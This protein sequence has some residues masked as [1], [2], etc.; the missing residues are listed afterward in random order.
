MTNDTFLFGSDS[1]LQFDTWLLLELLVLSA[2][3]RA[4]VKHV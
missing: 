4:G 1:G 3:S 2:S